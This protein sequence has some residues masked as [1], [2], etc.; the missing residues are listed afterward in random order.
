MRA[1]GALVQACMTPH[2]S[3]LTHSML[4]RR[5]GLNA[6]MCVQVCQSEMTWKRALAA[7]PAFMH[8]D[9]RLIA[10]S[11]SARFKRT[12]STSFRRHQPVPSWGQG[13]GGGGGAENEEV[14]S[15]L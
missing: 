2:T 15:R 1:S 12:S 11:L 8:T 5:R 6:L 13:G 7:M 14:V 3:M 4:S 10:S 9:T